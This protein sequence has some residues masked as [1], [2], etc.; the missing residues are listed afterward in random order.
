VNITEVRHRTTLLIGSIAG[1]ALFTRLLLF[2]RPDAGGS[3]ILGVHIHHLLIGVILIAIGGIP[4]VLLGSDSHLKSAA[5]SVFG[6]GLGLALDEWVLFVVRE[7]APDTAYLSG[8]SLTGASIFVV[9]VCGYAVLIY[10][11]LLGQERRSVVG[12][13]SQDGD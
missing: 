4:A 3:T 10:W 11:S 5:I 9:L 8:I 1:A 12:R 13:L 6:V 2:L 7:T